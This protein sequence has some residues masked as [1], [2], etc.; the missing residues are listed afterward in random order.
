MISGS[1]ERILSA[2]TYCSFVVVFSPIIN[3]D[4]GEF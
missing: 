1:P 2:L 3:K 4:L